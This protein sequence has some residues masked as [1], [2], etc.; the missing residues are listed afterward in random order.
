MNALKNEKNTIAEDLEVR[1]E[2]PEL[3]VRIRKLISAAVRV[4]ELKRGIGGTCPTPYLRV[5]RSERPTAGIYRSIRRRV[6]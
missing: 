6:G 5:R 4:W 3:P 1:S 2:R